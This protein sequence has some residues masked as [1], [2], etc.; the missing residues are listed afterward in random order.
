MSDAQTPDLA[1]TPDPAELDAPGGLAGEHRVLEAERIA[2]AATDG[3]GLNTIRQRLSPRRCWALEDVR[4]AFD[5]SFLAVAA[6]REYQRLDAELVRGELRLALFGHADPTGDDLYNKVLSGRRATAVYAVFKRDT[7]AWERLYSQPFGGDDWGVR[8]VQSMLEAVGFDV[9]GVDGVFGQQTRQAVEDFQGAHG[10]T[11]DGIAGPNTREALFLA[12]MDVLCVDAVGQPYVLGDEDFLGRGVQPGHAI[13]VQGCSEFNP[14]YSMSQ[15]RAQALASNKGERDAENAPNR[16]VVGFLFDA[17]L[18]VEAGHW[19]C[20]T[21]D[22]GPQGCRASF[23]P[24]GDARRQPGAEPREHAKGGRT[25]ACAFYDGLARFSP[26]EAKRAQMRLTL[27][28]P[29]FE[30]IPDAHYEIRAGGRLLRRGQANAG[31]V[32]VEPNMPMGPQLTVQF[33]E[34]PEGSHE[35]LALP[36]RTEVVFG[37]RG[38]HSLDADLLRLHNLGYPD[39]R[40]NPGRIAAFQMAQGI[41]PAT[42]ELDDATRQA[43]REAH[44][45]G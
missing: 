42:G 19:P 12:Y 27:L 11:V 30:P 3:D 34:R 20:P 16:R 7:A 36:H 41:E 38:D 40:D 22:E 8:S 17:A 13:D 10:L 14:I 15:A 21:V 9:G 4:F 28:D 44:G 18:V 29:E 25:M 26:C 35:A 39:A 6:R 45:D 23:W 1:S 5:S 43:A 33:G 24:D 37:L 31:G 2:V 32:L